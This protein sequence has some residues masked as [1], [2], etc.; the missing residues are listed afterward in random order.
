MRPSVTQA[1]VESGRPIGQE[2]Q[3]KPATEIRASAVWDWGSYQWI[4]VRIC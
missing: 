3:R 2:L 4:Y 1:G